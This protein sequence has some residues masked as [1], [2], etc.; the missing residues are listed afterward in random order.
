MTPQE[1]EAFLRR[2][3]AYDW[4]INDTRPMWTTSDLLEAIQRAGILPN[5]SRKLI[6]GWCERKLS[7]GGR[8]L[9]G[10]VNY[11]ST[12]G[13]RIPREDLLIF[14]AEGRAEKIASSPVS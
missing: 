10:A 14:F 3:K 9:P 1:A 6:N 8:A 13:W 4:L 2:Y 7:S 12:L 11:K 5:A